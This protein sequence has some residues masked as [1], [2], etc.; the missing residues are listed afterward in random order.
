[1]KHREAVG[2]GRVHGQHL[3]LQVGR[4]FGDLKPQVGQA[5]QVVV[6]VRL[7]LSH[8]VQVDD[9]RIPGWDLHALVAK[10][11]YPATDVLQVV[12]G[13]LIAQKLRQQDGW[14]LHRRHAGLLR[15]GSRV[16]TPRFGF[17]GRFAARGGRSVN[18]PGVCFK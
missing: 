14:A 8:L 18:N 9:A 5:T 1:M 17:A 16:D 7:R 12:V 6:G 4:Q 2:I 11:G 15:L 13:R 10:A 3:A